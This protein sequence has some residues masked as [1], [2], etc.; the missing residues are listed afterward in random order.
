MAKTFFAFI[1]G[2]FAFLFGK[3]SWTTPPWLAALKS[4]ATQHPKGFWSG[5]LALIVIVCGSYLGFLWYQNLPQPKL[6]VTQITPPKITPNEKTLIPHPLKIDFGI[7]TNGELSPRPVAPLS[8]VGKPVTQGIEMTPHLPGKW[9]WD[10]DSELTFTPDKDW[11]AGQT[12]TINVTQNF[13]APN[14]KIES[15]SYSFS[16]LPF[17]AVIDEIYFYQDPVNPKE[18]QLVATVM[19]S[20]PVDPNDFEQHIQLAYPA[21]DIGAHHYEKEN[22]KYTVSYDENK[23][24]AF[25]R[26]ENLSL[27]KIPRYLELTL[28]KGIKAAEGRS[29]TESVQQKNVLIPDAGSYL[30]IKKIDA[31]IVRN[32]K[33]QPEQILVIQSTLGV[34]QSALNKV[35]H[36]YQLP[37]DYPATHA[38]EAKPHY[39]WKEPGEITPA[40]L[41]KSQVLELQAVP[42]DHDFA[43]LHSYRFKATTPSYLYIKV[44]KGLMGLGDFSLSNDFT[45]ITKTPEFQQEITFLHKGAL[46]AL[47]TDEK[48][49]VLVRGLGSVKFN[50]ARVLPDDINHLITQTSG[51]F[52]D[53]SFIDPNFNQDNI[54]DISSEI[55]TFNADDPAKAQ[56]TALDLGKYSAVK[57]PGDK[58]PLGLFLLQAQGWDQETKTPLD[59][60]AKRLIL[61]TDMGLIVKDNSDGTHDI[62]VQSITKG[63]PLA[64]VSVEILGKNGLAIFTRQT[65]VSGH[66]IFPSLKDFVNEREP[67][68]YV[69]KNANDVSFIPYSRA[70]RQLNFSRFDISGIYNDDQNQHALSAFIFTDRG[71]YRPGDLA[72]IAMIVKQPFV[73]P[74]AA[75][76][77]LE[78]T[79]IDPRG[80]TVKNEKVVLNDSGYLTFDFKTSEVAPTGQYQINLYIVKDNHLSS[81]IGTS[82]IHVAEFLPDRLRIKAQLS[83]ESSAG[84]VSP[85]QLVT[86]VNLWNLYGAPASSHRIAGKITLAPKAVTF[87]AFP[88]YTFI[89][90]L[91]DPKSPPK[92][93]S[94]TLTDTKT[95]DQGK[96]ELALKLD[97][98]EKATYQLTVYAEGFEAEGGRSVTTQATALVSPLLYF[99]GYK[100]DGDLKYIKQ[101]DVRHVNLI[102]INP[103][104]KQQALDQ[105]TIKLYHLHPI[106][107]LVKKDDGSYQYQ[108]VIQQ[109]EVDTHPFAITEQG[110]DFTLPTN[111]IGDFQIIVSDASGSELSRFKYTVVGSGALPLPK[112]AELTVKL[113]KTEFM[114]GEEIEMQITAPYTGAG[115]ITIER[116]K[117]HAFQWFKADTT[118]SVQKIRIPA[119]FQGGG[120]VNIAF[121][122][123]LNSPEI[124]VSPL[125]YSIAP[126]TISHKNHE[127]KIDL[128][129]P[130]LAQPGETFPITYQTDKPSKI[131]VYAVDEGILQVTKYQTP[132]PIAFFF[133]K[134]AL[135]VNT[136]QILDQILPKFIADRE[137]S[138]VGG[139]MGALAI[140]KNLNPF[141]RKTDAPVVFWSG[142]MDADSTP[143]QLT[144]QI[145]DYFNG[146]L[147]VMAVAVAL[148]SVGA[149][150][151]SADVRGDFVINPNVP[152]FVAPSDEFEVTTSVANN[153]KGSG[154][155]AEIT[156]NLSS[157]SQL[158]LIGGAQQKLIVPE[159]QERSV[160]YKLRA[161]EQLGSAELVFS[162]SLNHKSSK[163]SSTLSIRPAS[164]YRT[165][166]T[167]G[168]T[169]D[170]KKE[171]SLSRVLYPEYQSGLAS[172]ARSPLILASGLQ[173]YLDKYPYGCTEQIVS[174]AFPLLMMSKQ[175]WF[176]TDA[177]KLH[178][179]IQER[180]QIV[181]QRQMSS[182]GFAYWPGSESAYGNDFASLYAMHFLTEA[183]ANNE[184]VPNDV[185][186]AGISYLKEYVTQEV[187][188]LNQ[189]RLHA[190][191]IY[192]LTR[193][194][195]V[196][197]SYLSNLQMILAKNKDIHWQNDITSVYLA[198]TYQMLQSND[199]ANKL[200]RLFKTKTAGDTE[201]TDFY[202]QAIGNAQYLYLVSMHFP[203]TAKHI[204]NGFV[205]S[206][207]DS[208]NSDSIS[209]V[210]ASYT[211]LGLAAYGQANPFAEDAGI[212]INAITKDGKSLSLSTQKAT[213]QKVSLSELVKTVIFQ[214]TDK[215]GYFYQVSQSGFD[216]TLPSKSINQGMEVFRE[217]HNANDE[218]LSDIHLGEELVVH[219]RARSTDDQY[220]YNIAIVDLLPGGFE[221]VRD[222]IKLQDMEYVD[223]REDRVIFFGGIGPESKDITYRIKATNL[224]KYIVPAIVGM[225][226]YH[227]QMKSVGITSNI[228]VK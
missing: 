179:K 198:A 192:L 98:F 71:I 7:I 102:A 91:F 18:R 216:K 52:N 111:D 125:S 26:S 30:K 12:Y 58:H 44:D 66:A 86:K 48:L 80:N 81:L 223:V 136:Q 149:A 159:G 171:I 199:E 13:Y 89:D 169:T 101:N 124:F 104:L 103:N 79:I 226:M 166:L 129:I 122:R 155:D 142:I 191:A 38:E 172:A 27:P 76:I 114:P 138:A 31:A 43:K 112:N 140:N 14:T 168:Y 180:I 4:Q 39:E 19:F 145:P 204:D 60:Q 94:H 177:D 3:I 200:L 221:V 24:T 217:Y 181:T 156:I 2:L 178:A 195:I 32:P 70:D 176:A 152:T 85:N 64:N 29:T 54:S 161:N 133:Q 119:E 208:L 72:H 106:T 75:G 147:H 109:T 157:P 20:Y 207:V 56:Y 97:R 174:Q 11:P 201:I 197:T 113:N 167:S 117:V 131:I 121:V 53:P 163:M 41:A 222:S 158:E 189:A 17:D 190:Y 95:D 153:V 144:Y 137:L 82:S 25:I 154:N 220:H 62:F 61:I 146:S 184:A 5:F 188:N 127:I 35:I 77:P 214:Q 143:K 93:Y 151:K 15:L 224:G 10:T 68:V 160:H 165:D 211:S 135:E 99:V 49:S 126:F 92:T 78:A 65:D 228:E 205:S 218:S 175:P 90:P 203:D 69:A 74:Q 105:L 213:Y 185:F 110:T 193:N 88:Q 57:I 100:P 33:D 202:N 120:Y 50:F 55:Q 194:E 47:G 73:M 187:T 1:S 141:K 87:S 212:S 130:S 59:A 40:I 6:I 215:T 34:T 115:L 23:R 28:S 148:D 150:E 21:L 45:T 63:T 128:T 16:T 37:Q 186:S 51:D 219:L 139:D 42:S 118:A 183:R 84:W 206:L 107:T 46:L 9:Q 162:A 36:V 134:H 116:D 83:P 210:L 108:S 132:N 8:L 123:D 173:E 196:T 67:T 209:T 22:I 170:M 227:P 164:P 96:A 225:A 182:G